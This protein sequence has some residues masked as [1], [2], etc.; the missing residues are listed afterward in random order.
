[1][2]MTTSFLEDELIF[3]KENERRKRPHEAAPKY[4]A[5]E[6]TKSNQ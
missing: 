1:M 6:G 3:Y 2:Y 4:F 5:N